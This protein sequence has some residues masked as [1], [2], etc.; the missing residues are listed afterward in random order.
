MGTL[1]KRT[2]ERLELEFEPG[3]R[4][5]L[6]KSVLKDNRERVMVLGGGWYRCPTFLVSPNVIAV[7]IRGYPCTPG[8]TGVENP[9]P[10]I[11][12]SMIETA[13]SEPTV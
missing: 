3:H 1:G 5:V 9:R 7:H 11:Q 10:S 4:L 13:I 6:S 8:S 2:V 12:P